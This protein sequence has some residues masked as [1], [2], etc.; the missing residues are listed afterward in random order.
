MKS[1]ISLGTLNKHGL[2]MRRIF[3]FLLLIAVTVSAVACSDKDG[4]ID[5]PNAKPIVDNSDKVVMSYEGARITSGMYAFIFSALKTNYLYLLQLYGDTEFVEDNESF[6]NTKTEDGKTL[7]QAV[8]KDINDHCKM[9]LVCEKM[10]KEYGVELDEDAISEAEDEYNDYIAS[11]GG[12]KQLEVYINRYGISL[13]E[14]QSYLNR[15]QLINCLQDKL[16]E[17]GGLCAVSDSDVNEQVK[18]DYIKAKHIYLLNT[19]YDGK[20][21]DKANEILSD[22]KS[23]T[24]KYD[25]FVK[26][27]ADDSA[28]AYPKGFMVNLEETEDAYAELLGSLKKDEYGVCEAAD[29][30][31]VICRLEMSDEDVA[32]KHDAVWTKLADEK[33]ADTIS[34]RYDMVEL[35]K[36]ELNRYDIV[37]ADII[38]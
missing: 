5:D 15:K 8:V 30:A 26:L 23:G 22:I 9:I 29:G 27:S 17:K 10:A 13:E 7:A 32:S 21:I 36:E 1:I 11:Y 4:V 38:Q 25:D 19:A 12:E 3:A 14:L 35:D 6:W 20:A 37:T 31:Y 28:T 18:K 33:F 2:I 16:C 24:K 34:L